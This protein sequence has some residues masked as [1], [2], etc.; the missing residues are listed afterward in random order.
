MSK[1][2]KDKNKTK[3]ILN[4]L[5]SYFITDALK[6]LSAKNEIND[7]AVMLKNSNQRLWLLHERLEKIRHD[8]K[9]NYKSYDYGNGYYYQSMKSINISGYRDTEDRIK[10]L[11]LMD[12]LKGKSI[13]DIGSNTGFLLLS[14]GDSLK[15]GVGVELN[16]YLVE[17]SDEV[18]KYTGLRNIDFISSSF[19]D[20]NPSNKKFDVILSLANHSTFDGNTKQSLEDYF[21]K[22]STLL[23]N[24]GKLIFES[25][26]PQI[27]PV[28]KLEKTLA[29]ISKYFEIEDKPIIAM[30]G[31]LD[32]NRTYVVGRKKLR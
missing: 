4:K 30:K 26:P 5:K 25:H 12:R 3:C 15:E 8:I 1:L 32:K 13:L 27:E 19:E 31:F 18:K 10:Q 9:E 20:Y 23:A 22:I 6:R 2:Y 7:Y 21:K 28:E 14:L 17:T 24:N 11:D 16:Q 29:L